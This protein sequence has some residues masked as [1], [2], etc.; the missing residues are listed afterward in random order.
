MVARVAEPALV[1]LRKRRLRLEVGAGQIVEQDVEAGIEQVPPPARQMIEQ[2]LLVLQQTIMAAVELVD[3]R[4]AEIGAQQIE[5]APCARTTADA[6]AIRCPAPAADRRPGRTAPDPSASPC[7]WRQ[8]FGPEP[9]KL[10]LLPQPQR[11]PAR[12]PLPRS[13]QPEFG[14]L[15]PDNHRI[16]QNPVTA[17]LRESASVRRRSQPSSRTS[18]DLRHASSWESL[19]SPKYSRCVAPRVRGQR[20]VL[21][22]AP[23]AVV[24]AVF[25]PDSPPQK[26]GGEPIRNSAPPKCPRSSLQPFSANFRHCTFV[27][28]MA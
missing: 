5:P 24:L 15:Q 27:I 4:Q 25:L 23:V 18:I 6:G 11:Q 9:V 14:R 19:I 16:R 3:F 26:H 28:S 8:P 10:Q 12:S 13:A 21:N 1:A 20:A 22:N 7:D 17:I 2:R